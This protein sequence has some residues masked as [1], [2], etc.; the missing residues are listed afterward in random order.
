MKR[1]I[2]WRIIITFIVILLSNIVV[3]SVEVS[4]R[5]KNSTV[6]DTSTSNAWNLFLKENDFNNL[7]LV[8]AG[9]YPASPTS[10]F[11][12]IF[13]LL[14][15]K[16]NRPFL[17]WPAIDFSTTKDEN[18]S[19]DF[20]LKGIF[21][22]LAGEY[23]IVPFIEKYREY[24]F[25]ESRP[26]W[27]FRF[28]LSNVEKDNFLHNVFNL[29]NK[30]YP[31][32]FSNKNC[33]SQIDSLLRISLNEPST[34]ERLIFFPKTILNNW[35]SRIDKPM[36][37]ESMNNIIYDNFRNSKL[38]I[39]NDIYD[40][41]KLSNAE[42]ALL[43]DKL[44]WK[45]SHE[46]NH[47]TERQKDYLKKLRIAVSTS[48]GNAIGIFKK[49]KKEFD[50]HPSMFA[51]S[52]INLINGNTFE[53]LI[54]YRFGLHEFYENTS[55]Y[56]TNDYLSLLKIEIGLRNKNIRLNEFFL[57][58]QLSLQPISPLFNYLSWRIGLGIEREIEYNNTPLAY[59][60]FNGIGYTVPIIKNNVNLSLLADVSPIYVQHYGFSV[61]YGP[62]AILQ[63]Y[64]NSN[65]KLMNNFREIFTSRKDIKNIF[66][67]ETSIGVD[68]SKLITTLFQF[69][70]SK[71]NKW[72]SIK[73]NYYLN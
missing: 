59:G 21:G 34:N 62:E 28:H 15:P 16:E 2:T 38:D 27:L 12:H 20:F 67:N 32:R 46:T 56:P 43:L 64:F 13:I 58:N 45:Y 5:G 37:I 18:G 65:I 41:K 54:N 42:L 24:T 51:G 19:L 47:L 70:Y 57:F 26:L 66:Y 25:I 11:G 3:F 40:I 1:I 29:Q 9:P 48:K 10:S 39:S 31:Y 53:Y 36:Y 33:A 71:Y 30:H 63:I 50:L 7:Y 44:E 52:G 22:G 35:G 49:Y 61:L 55:V 14:E 72:Y 23:R 60:L 68:L 6:Q 73:L 8:F 17:L 69:K 4:Q